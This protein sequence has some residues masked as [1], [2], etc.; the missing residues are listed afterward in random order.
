MMSDISQIE[1]YL[2]SKSVLRTIGDKLPGKYCD[3]KQQWVV[4][5]NGSSAPIVDVAD[6]MTSVA[7]K[8]FNNTEQDDK[9]SHFLMVQ[10]KTEAQIESEDKV[11]EMIP[12]M[13]QT[14]TKVDNE[15]DDTQLSADIGWL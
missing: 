3:L 1:P 8:T 2:F 11:V 6:V 14:K 13:V 4:P 9:H 5:Y 7:T 15:D 10:T 12:L